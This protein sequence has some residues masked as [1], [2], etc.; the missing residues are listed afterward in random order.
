MQDQQWNGMR[1]NKIAKRLLERMGK[2]IDPQMMH[3][4]QLLQE[5]LAIPVEQRGRIVMGDELSITETATQ[6]PM[7]SPTQQAQILVAGVEGE[8][9]E[10]RLDA[11]ADRLEG[12]HAEQA[13][14]FLA[15][16]VAIHLEPE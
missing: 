9:L 15:E 6:M 11:L 14:L 2:S 10:D 7:F 8:N 3:S 1:I 13:G 5:Y 12:V 16:N 4:T